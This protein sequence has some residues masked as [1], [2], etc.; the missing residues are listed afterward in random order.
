MGT[1]SALFLRQPGHERLG[2]ALS[3]VELIVQVSY[4]RRY[5]PVHEVLGAGRVRQNARK[6]S[7]ERTGKCGVGGAT[8]SGA[9]VG[10]K[11]LL[12][13]RRCRSG[14]G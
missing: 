12:S 1:P 6:V 2:L 4:V 11:R 9:P 10:S 3:R 7:R 8:Y 5:V 14:P 13:L